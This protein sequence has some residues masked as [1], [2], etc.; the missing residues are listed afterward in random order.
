MSIIQ[1]NK[2]EG[3]ERKPGKIAQELKKVKT[4]DC[5]D[6]VNYIII[7]WKGGNCNLKLGR[8]EG[9]LKKVC[10]NITK[11]K[12]KKQKSDCNDLNCEL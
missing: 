9:K 8:N 2:I 11:S 7:K 4:R 5:R 6:L 3:F 12:K 1:K 10:E